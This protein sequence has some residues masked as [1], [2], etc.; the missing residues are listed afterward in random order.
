MKTQQIIY[1]KDTSIILND[2]AYLQIGVERPYSIPISETIIKQ[3]GQWSEIYEFNLVLS[4]NGKDYSVSDRDILEFGDVYFNPLRISIKETNDPYLIIDLA[5]E[6][7][8][9]A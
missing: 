3:N 9:E 5:Y 6:T 2:V 8:E 7:A 4:I 1:P